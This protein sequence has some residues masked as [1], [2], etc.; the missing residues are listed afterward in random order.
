MEWLKLEGDDEENVL[1]RGNRVIIGDRRVSIEEEEDDED[2]IFTL[3][4]I[5]ATTSDGGFYRCKTTNNDPVEE[6]VLVK[7]GGK[8]WNYWNCF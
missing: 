1:T 7:V 4:V 2:L 5:R 6:D 3:T 8:Q